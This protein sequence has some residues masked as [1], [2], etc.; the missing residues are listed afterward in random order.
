MKTL[1]SQLADSLS[2]GAA[3]LC[4]CWL[5]TRRDGARFGATDHDRDLLVDG[6]Q[7]PP[8]AG[9]SGGQF[10][11][12]LDLAPG[13][14]AA[15]GALSAAFLTDADFAAGLWD[16]ARVDV[17]RVDWSAP[18]HRVHVW[19]G[20]LGEIARSGEVF[21]AELVSLKADLERRI[22]RVYARDCDAEIGD[23]RC[24]VDL[25]DPAFRAEGVADVVLAADRLR[26]SAASG[27]ASGWFAGGRL[28]RA[29]GENL[30]ILAHEGDVLTL[31]RNADIIQN[32]LLIATAGCNKRFETCRTKFSNQENFRGFPHLPGMDAVLSG[33]AGDGSDDGGKR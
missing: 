33:P 14:A 28:I 7:C 18:E 21:R 22:G 24:G 27:F 29:S 20:R 15:S 19:S 26:M 30:R 3:T 17:F 2:A 5:F 25:D 11:S 13:R 1:P 10:V 31:A 9:L 23:A 4:L 8:E 32:E 6:V 12:G 16:G